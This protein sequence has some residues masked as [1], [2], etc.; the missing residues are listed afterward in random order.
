MLCQFRH[1]RW[2]KLSPGG[3]LDGRRPEEEDRENAVR[4]RSI[5]TPRGSRGGSSS[6]ELAF[7]GINTSRQR[8][9][10]CYPCV[11]YEVS[12]VSQAAQSLSGALGG[13]RTPDPQIRSRK[14]GA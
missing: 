11:R 3:K 13:I 2:E 1:Y 7:H 12:P 4:H 10:K 14:F 8:G 9:I 6:T 5:G